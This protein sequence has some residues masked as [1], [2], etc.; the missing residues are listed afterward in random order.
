MRIL[1]IEKIK[2]NKKGVVLLLTLLILSSILVVTLGA[3]DLVI[4][5][6]KMNRQT[7]YSGI[8]FFAAEA[9]MERALW[10]ARKNNLVLSNGN[11]N[12]IFNCPGNPPACPLSNSSSYVVDYATSTP[13][14]TFKSIG[15][16][17]GVKRSVESTYQ[18]Q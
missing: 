3:A 18:S 16:Y 9:G 12:N 13:K 8:A 7:G 2:G 14:I 11:V 15:S 4:A 1:Q 10:E 5:G 17:L 6:V